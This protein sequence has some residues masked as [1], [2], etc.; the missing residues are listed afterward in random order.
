M[1]NSDRSDV[2]EPIAIIGMGNLQHFSG[3]ISEI[4]LIKDSLSIAR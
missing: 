3:T 1:A 4:R 2:M